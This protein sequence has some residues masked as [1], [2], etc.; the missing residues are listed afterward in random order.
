MPEPIIKRYPLELFGYP[1]TDQSETAQ[2]VRAEQYC[3]FLGGICKKPRKSE[4]HIK[5]G[6]CSVGYK[7]EFSGKFLPVI[8]CPHRFDTP[9][10]FKA[11]EEDY[12]GPLAADEKVMW[13]TEVSLGVAGSVDYVA[14]KVKEEGIIDITSDFVCVKL[15]AAGTTGTPWQAFLEH[16]QTGK[17]Q[18]D[19]YKY[20]IN[21]ANEFLKTMMQQVYKKGVIIESWGKRMIFVIQDVALAYLRN[22]CDTSG[23]RPADPADPVHFYTFSMKWDDNS[24]A[25]LLELDK[26]VSTNTEGIRRILAGANKDTF[27]TLDK[28]MSNV[29]RKLTQ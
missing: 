15:Q 29:A 16:K 25:W 28:F 9:L 1:Y 26:K 12:F 11:I 5:I 13:A 23:L 6:I 7:G 10:L 18:S 22:A 8:I 20:G 19:S 4:P 14:V 21:W 17:F 24:N 2:Q 27:P 3:P